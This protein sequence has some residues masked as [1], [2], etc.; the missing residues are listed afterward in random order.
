MHT[1]RS[2][3]NPTSD[4][5]VGLKPDLQGMRPDS[6]YEQAML[7]IKVADGLLLRPLSLRERDGVGVILRM[8]PAC[9]T[10]TLCCQAFLPDAL[11]ANYVQPNLF[12]TNLS[13]RERDHTRRCV[14][15]CQIRNH[16]GLTA[17][18]MCACN[19]LLR[20]RLLHRTPAPE[21]DQY[22]RLAPTALLTPQLLAKN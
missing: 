7:N 19:F 4:I 21:H 22:H 18:N 11:R 14:S 17:E 10:L 8:V 6:Y 15:L 16:A 1:C 5:A 9:S 13:L 20:M 2:G 12:Q 3:F